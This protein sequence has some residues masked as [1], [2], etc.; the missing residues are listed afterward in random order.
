M[1]EKGFRFTSRP[2]AIVWVAV[3]F[4]SA[5]GLMRELKVEREG[6]M[7]DSMLLY[8]SAIL[9]WIVLVVLITGL[10]LDVARK[11]RNSRRRAQLKEEEYSIMG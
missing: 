4:G 2:W 10:M 8:T 3:F 1:A 5:I 6:S 7:I 9:Y 11:T